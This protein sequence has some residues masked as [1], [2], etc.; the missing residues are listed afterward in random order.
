MNREIQTQI[1]GYQQIKL[2]VMAHAFY[3]HTWRQMEADLC[4]FA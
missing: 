2:D 4:E 3:S 1:N